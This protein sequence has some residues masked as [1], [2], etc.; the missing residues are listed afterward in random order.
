LE[1]RKGKE[2]AR[3]VRRKRMLGQKEQ[4]SSSAILPFSKD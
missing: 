4:Y 3:E 1:C 2:P